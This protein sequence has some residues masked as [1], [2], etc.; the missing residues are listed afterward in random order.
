MISKLESLKKKKGS[1]NIKYLKSLPIWFL[2]P[3]QNVSES[4]QES[5]CYHSQLGTFW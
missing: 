5:Y 3:F 4:L 1:V 2:P